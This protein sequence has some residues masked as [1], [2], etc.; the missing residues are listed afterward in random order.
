MPSNAADRI[1]L[2]LSV[3]GPIENGVNS[4]DSIVNRK[5][6][7]MVLKNNII[8]KLFPGVTCTKKPPAFYQWFFNQNRK[9]FMNYDFLTNSMVNVIINT[10][11]AVAVNVIGAIM[12][13]TISFGSGTLVL[14]L[15]ML[16]ACT[17]LVTFSTNPV[18]ELGIAA[19]FMFSFNSVAEISS[20]V[21]AF[22]SL[23]P[24][25]LMY[26]ELSFLNSTH[27]LSGDEQFTW[28]SKAP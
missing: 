26:I 4:F 11:G 5:S 23:A 9:Y 7:Y 15:K 24:S 20:H 27:D 19:L 12:A 6:F 17:I 1:V 2:F 3:T 13:A 10:E 28:L 8:F 22:N 21:P 16:L 18:G 14:P 25:Q